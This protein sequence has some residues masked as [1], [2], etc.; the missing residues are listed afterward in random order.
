MIGKNGSASWCDVTIGVIREEYAV[1][2]M[3]PELD[4]T[5]NCAACSRT[6]WAKPETQRWKESGSSVLRQ[7]LARFS[8]ISRP[9]SSLAIAAAQS[10]VGRDAFVFLFDWRS[11][12]SGI[13]SCH[14]IDLPF[15]FG[16]IRWKAAPMLGG[17]DRREVEE[18]SRLFKGA[19]AAF[20]EN[21]D[22]NGRGL[23]LWPSR[24]APYCTSIAALPHRVGLIDQAPG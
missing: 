22:P 16:N 24:D 7:R 18:L 1:V 6:G 13:E 3:Y 23:P 19:F 4:Q 21:G 15:L 2:S 5:S 10:K 11:L 17:A 12:K 9:S 8:E 20:V 14:S